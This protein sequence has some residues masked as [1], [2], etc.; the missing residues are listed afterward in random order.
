MVKFC[1][2]AFSQ[3]PFTFTMTFMTNNGTGTGELA[4]SIDTVDGI[5]VED[6]EIVCKS[7][8]TY[9]A[10]WNLNA[11]PDSNCQEPPCEM[12]LPRVYKVTFG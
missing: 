7:P 4:I 2:V 1:L 8:G 9:T 10:Q 6:G 3:G 11:V 5:P 12:W